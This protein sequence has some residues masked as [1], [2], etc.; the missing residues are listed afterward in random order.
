MKWTYFNVVHCCVWGL[1]RAR[2]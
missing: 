1:R 2:L